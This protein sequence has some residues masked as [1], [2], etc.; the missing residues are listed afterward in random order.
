MLRG[1]K[2]LVELDHSLLQE[3]A[4]LRYFPPALLPNCQPQDSMPR[5]LIPHFPSHLSRCLDR[6]LVSPAASLSLLL[7]PEI[8]AALLM[9]YLPPTMMSRFSAPDLKLQSESVPVLEKSI[10]PDVESD[11]RSESLASEKVERVP[12]PNAPE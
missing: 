1:K 6:M 2:I 12:I 4:L 9:G 10:E 5:H 8:Q 3:M 11:S 7:V